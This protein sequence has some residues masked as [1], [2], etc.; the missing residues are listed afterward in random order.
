MTASGRKDNRGG[1]REGA[2]RKAVFELGNQER[3][4]IIKKVEEQA[5]RFR[6]GEADVRPKC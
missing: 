5:N 1:K 3:S 4:D 6:V 2:G